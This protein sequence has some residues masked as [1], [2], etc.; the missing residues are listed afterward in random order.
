MRVRFHLG[1]SCL[2]PALCGGTSY[3][4]PR[5]CRQFGARVRLERHGR[6]RGK[7]SRA[8]RASQGARE[9]RSHRIVL[10]SLLVNFRVVSVVLSMHVVVFVLVS[11]GR[12]PAR[13]RI[14]VGFR[15]PTSRHDKMR[16]L[17]FAH[18]VPLPR[19]WHTFSP[20]LRTVF[21]SPPFNLW[22]P[23]PML[24]PSSQI[25]RRAFQSGLP[26][27]LMRTFSF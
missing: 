22:L 20:F 10:S 23:S 8:S 2:C 14:E 11:F 25:L 24:G 16:D 21:C 5:G 4:R 1:Q 7:E 19:R 18:L 26:P 6:R 27:L 12:S 17:A 9:K 3:S 15:A 13:R